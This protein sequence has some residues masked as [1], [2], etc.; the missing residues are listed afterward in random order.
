MRKL[1]IIFFIAAAVCAVA[2]ASPAYDEIK[3]QAEKAYAE[4]SYRIAHD[5]YLKAESLADSPLQARWVRFRL[6]DTLWRAGTATR[7]SDDTNFE[8]ARK[9][10]EILIR[11][12]VLDEDKDIV[13]AEVCE[14]LGDFWWLRPQSRNLSQGWQYYQKALDWWAGSTDIEMARSRYLNIV[15][16]IAQVESRVDFDYYSYYYYQMGAVPLEVFE[17]ALKIARTADD[18]A[19]FRYVI[20]VCLRSRAG[21]PASR[22]RA[23]DELAEIVKEGK[24]T[25][26]YDDALF[27]LASM[28]ENEGIPEINDDGTWKQEQDLKKALEFFERIAKEFKKGETR[29]Y[30][31]AQAAIKRITGSDLNISAPGIFLPDSEIQIS[32]SSRNI[33]KVNFTLYRID[34]VRDANFVSDTGRSTYDFLARISIS[35]AEKVKSWSKETGDTGDYKPRSE[36]VR[37]EGKLQPGA[38]LLEASSGE[39]SRRELVLVSD[40]VL[41]TKTS[42]TRVLAYFC[43]AYD[44]A[45]I[46]DGTMKLWMNEYN[47]AGWV[48]NEYNGE[49]DEN[50]MYIFKLKDNPSRSQ[51]FISAR[52]GDRQAFL[53]GYGGYYRSQPFQWRFYAYT[54]RPAYRPGETVQWK[55]IVRKYDGADYFVP[56]DENISYEIY[57]PR[58]SKI[59]DGTMKLNTFGS[60]WGSITLDSTMPLGEYTIRF[61]TPQTGAV[62]SAVLFRL[63]EYKLPEFKVNVQ[64]PEENGRRKVFSPGDILEAAVTAEYYFGGPVAN[65]NVEIIIY[66]RPFYH[67]WYPQR[68]FPWFYENMMQ[69]RYYR[70]WQGQIV[71]RDVVKTDAEGKAT[72]T[73]QTPA[74]AGQ[75][76][77]YT[78]EARVTDASRREIVGS[79]TVRVTRQRFYI[80]PY[81]EHCLYRPGDRVSVNFKAIDAN[82][83]PVQTEGTVKVTRERWREVWV[84]PEGKEV[85]RESSKSAGGIRNMVIPPEKG[86]T[87][88]FRGYAQEEV[89]VRKMRT[90]SQGNAEIVFTADREGYYR[91]RWTSVV[92]KAVPITADTTIWVATGKSTDIG[93][94]H[95][96]V[97]IIVDRDTF[98]AGQT[99]PVMLT[100][101][102]GENWIL[103]TIESED[104]LTQRLIHMDG[105]AKLLEIPVE[106]G[107]VPNIFLS[108]VMVNDLQMFADSKEVVVPPVKHFLNLELSFDRGTYQPGEEGTLTLYT[109][110]YDNKPVS[111]E[112]SL[113]LV[114]ESVFYIQQD[115][116]G[117][118]RQ[119]YYGTKRQ[120]AVQ[121]FC[122]FQQKGY[123]K[124]VVGDD[125]KLIDERDKQKLESP[126]A[127]MAQRGDRSVSYAGLR[128]AEK[129]GVMK[130]Q[131][132]AFEMAMP[133]AAGAPVPEEAAMKRVSTG[134]GKGAPAGAEAAVVVRTDFRSTMFWQ[135]DIVTD[136]DGTARIK[137][138]YPGSLTT[139]KATAR[140]VGAGNSFGIASNSAQTRKPLMVRLEAPRFFVVGDNVIISALINNSTDKE[141]SAVP[142]LLSSGL[143]ITGFLKDGKVSSGQPSSVKVPAHGEVRIDWLAAVKEPGNARLQVSARSTVDSDAMEK[144]FVVFDHGIEKFIGKSGKISASEAVISV[145]I[146]KE[147][148]TESTEMAVYVSPSI[149]I[150]M[151]DALPYLINYPY[152]C[153]EQTMSRF[154]PTVI[155][156]RT[157]AEM[158]LKPADIEGRVFGGIEKQG[159]GKT[160]PAGKQEIGKIADMVKAGLARLYDFQHPDGGWG[161]WKEGESDHFMT[162][163]VLWGLLLAQ[164]SD[165]S[166]KQDVI[167]RAMKYLETEIVEEENNFDMQAWMLHS[168]SVGYSGKSSRQVSPYAVKAF[169]NLWN[170]RERGNAYTCA[171]L[172]LAAKNLG[173]TGKAEVLLRNLENGVKFD[174]TP[175][176]S[177]LVKNSRHDEVTLAT[178]HWGEDRIAWRWSDGC[179]EATSWV[180]R[181]ILAVDPG[182]KLVE[183]AMNWLVKN[184]RGAQWSNTR[185]TAMAILALND[186][187]KKSG[188]LAPET[189]Y[190]VVVNGRGIGSRKIKPSEILSAQSVFAVDR[191]F[192]RDG[193]NEIT[194]LRSKGKSP[195]YFSV[196]VSF[197]TRE[198]PVTAAG[199]EMFIKRICNQLT[200][201]PTLLKGYVYEKKLLGDNET[202]AS[203]DRVEVSLVIETKNDAEYLVFEDLKPAGLEV[204]QLRSGEPLY[205]RELKSGAIERRFKE[206]RKPD[207]SDYTG[208]VRLVYQELRDRKVVCFIDKLP[209]GIWEISYQLRAEIPG[210]FHWLPVLGHAMYVPEIRCNGDEIRIKVEEQGSI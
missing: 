116:A 35:K 197:F 41:V 125:G 52:S 92:K 108:A 93:Y 15:R 160:Q 207:P 182:N 74:N 66:Q 102:G 166:V 143:E 89:L 181:A 132:E 48:W 171:L 70:G 178:A 154:L 11:D 130:E 120:H 47:G 203:G 23:A 157:L 97:E 45:P 105:T 131:A 56:G 140:A 61:A 168:L 205:A 169:D 19:H 158:G 128:D 78:I 30:D 191:K 100:T 20:A 170:N 69:K 133:L 106:E 139:W 68:D 62:A 146:P 39:L 112:V 95:G 199:N 27:A 63:E 77:E 18:R 58:G 14:S 135:P 72:F 24:G 6:A 4:G 145:N 173:Y 57:D 42:G 25:Q 103:F 54:D 37:I 53:A 3:T 172:A 13:W 118:P 40:A 124:L 107:Y 198:E 64:V 174:T 202:L 134:E 98:R 7:T 91:V 71:K 55:C 101:Q 90:D 99:A 17:N 79:G 114:D 183:P 83:Q 150:T 126:E 162:G 51:F 189:E 208:R 5:L 50:G 184:R 142:A 8:T 9:Q 67:W 152:G 16:K 87:L 164:S 121:M 94:R 156:A 88:K 49:T 192:I 155:T 144:E 36:L 206:G 34:L 119:F 96:G 163:Y 159:A 2:G 210:M 179:I 187:L 129:S 85:I 195:L 21:D 115:Y 22:K 1:L 122:S 188:E 136:Q 180:L 201:K 59:K 194:I 196:Q 10:L 29:Y 12:I 33:K 137:V 193:L 76:F 141:I 26:W 177:V 190:S 127:N 186:Y 148:K 185:D 75:D 110:D 84:T 151:L 117:D 81:A 65:A 176:T 43:S 204:V 44:G 113:G 60:D 109:R 153:T 161:W 32:L 123:M 82:D 28:I 38:Y 73:F 31:Q 111:A 138:K 175:D 200:G 167:D 147:R 86:Y 165:I 104:I 80:H 46:N 209:Q 149:A